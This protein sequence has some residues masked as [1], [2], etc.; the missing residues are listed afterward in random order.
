[1]IFMSCYSG[2]PGFLNDP[3]IQKPHSSSD[4]NGNPLFFL[5]TP[6][7]QPVKGRF[8]FIEICCVPLFSGP[9]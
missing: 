6:Y 9:S 7:F 5:I 1:M 8:R 4:K 2:F 3:V